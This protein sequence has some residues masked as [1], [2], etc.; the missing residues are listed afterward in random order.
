MGC[1]MEWN[2]MW[3]GMEWD[4]ESN[5]MGYGMEW[6]V[7]WNIILKISTEIP[8]FTTMATVKKYVYS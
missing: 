3:N 1:G 2:G 5:G 4:V 8:T 7:E 6:D